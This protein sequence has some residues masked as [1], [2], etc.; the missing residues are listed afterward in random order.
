MARRT[1]AEL[2][3]D[4]A[5]ARY[6]GANE[7]AVLLRKMSELGLGLSAVTGALTG[8]LEQL[9]REVEEKRDA[10]RESKRPPAAPKGT[11]AAP[12]A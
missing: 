5:R 1:L 10:A 7:V 3:A 9:L 11:A 2:E 12:D 8:H 6:D 4:L